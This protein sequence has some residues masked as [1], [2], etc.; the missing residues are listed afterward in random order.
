[1]ETPRRGVRLM[2]AR[3]LAV[4]LLII[5]LAVLIALS[6]EGVRGWR[7][8]R[9][10]VAEARANIAKEMRDNKAEIEKLPPGYARMRAQLEAAADA[11]RSI[12]DTKQGP[13]QLQLDFEFAELTTVSR[14][15]AELTGA[16]AL[17]TYEEVRGYESVYELQRMF[18]DTERRLYQEFL[19]VISFVRLAA[20]PGRAQLTEITEWTR[21]I[22]VVR[23]GVDVLEQL[24]RRLSTAYSAALQ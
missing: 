7:A 22:H 14:T 2:S 9:A 4:E 11:A 5:V 16:L 10:K 21:Q 13:N 19:N 12:L 1:M 3:E 18:A 17:M 20:E 15:T 6:V 23:T 8:D 24:A